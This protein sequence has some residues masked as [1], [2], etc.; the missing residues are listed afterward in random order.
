MKTDVGA[1]DPHICPANSSDSTLT[2]SKN[3]GKDNHQAVP[4]TLQALLYALSKQ[5]LQAFR[6][7]LH[8]FRQNRYTL[9]LILTVALF[10]LSTTPS[11]AQ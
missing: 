7:F 3:V 10:C 8:C 5:D 6:N 4:D 2:P 9:K 1:R 11:I